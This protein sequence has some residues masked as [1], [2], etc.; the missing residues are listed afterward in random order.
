MLHL[1]HTVHGARGLESTVAQGFVM[2]GFKVLL[3]RVVDGPL[4]ASCCLVS[5]TPCVYTR[6]TRVFW[7]LQTDRADRQTDRQSRQTHRQT[8]R[9]TGSWSRQTDRQ[10]VR[11]SKQAKQTHRQTEKTGIVDRDY[12]QREQIGRQTLQTDIA[13]RH[14]R[15]TELTDRAD[16]Q[17]EQTDRADR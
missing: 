11:Q 13:D 16:R 3:H 2:Q 1:I 15:Q 8:G 5:R 14:S 6:Y 7:A 17:T 12:R 4:Q 9:K 10:K